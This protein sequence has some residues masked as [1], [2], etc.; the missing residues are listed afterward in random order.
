MLTAEVIIFWVTF[1][2]MSVPQII[3]LFMK[4]ESLEEA[5][6]DEDEEE[7]APEGDKKE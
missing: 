3:F 2:I 4:T 5:M 1:H 6:K 7:D